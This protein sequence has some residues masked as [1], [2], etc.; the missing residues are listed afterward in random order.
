M[1]QEC[2][3]SQAGAQSALYIKGIPNNLANQDL[4]ER[5]NNQQVAQEIQAGGEKKNKSKFINLLKAYLT[6]KKSSNL[7]EQI[8]MMLPQDFFDQYTQREYENEISFKGYR[9]QGSSKW[10]KEDVLS[11]D[12]DLDMID[13]LLYDSFLGENFIKC[14]FRYYSLLPE[15]V[16]EI[17]IDMHLDNFAVC[18]AEISKTSG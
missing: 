11:V 6:E 10:N 5:M 7:Y 2:S 18:A 1:S 16:K 9:K 12:L 17:F 4:L 14:L 8:N 3:L 15:Y 13:M